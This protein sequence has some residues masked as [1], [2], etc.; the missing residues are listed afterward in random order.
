MMRLFLCGDL[1]KNYHLTYSYDRGF[2]GVGFDKYHGMIFTMLENGGKIAIM[3]GD[4]DKLSDSKSL[5]N[6]ISTI[7]TIDGDEHDLRFFDS[8]V[9]SGAFVILQEKGEAKK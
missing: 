3:Q 7:P 6:F 2:Q 9:K 5:S 8:K 1:P 4:F